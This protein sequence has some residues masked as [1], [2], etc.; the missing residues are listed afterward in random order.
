MQC[1][2]YLILGS[3]IGDREA[4]LSSASSLLS[5]NDLSIVK[6]SRLYETE[7]WGNINQAGF[8]NQALKIETS[9]SPL[10]LLQRC[11]KVEEEIGRVRIEKW[12]P[13]I[14]DIDIA[15]Y[16]NLIL[17][18]EEL[19]IPQHSLEKRKFALIPLTEISAHKIHPL[20]LKSNKD[21]LSEC[22]DSLTVKTVDA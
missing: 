10:S 18:V 19:K 15:Y 4:N 13:R 8:Y 20:L 14:I 7:A 11:L 22:D 2:A 17:Q 12:G 5:A 21:L 9:L 1:T 16:E 6:S 3:N